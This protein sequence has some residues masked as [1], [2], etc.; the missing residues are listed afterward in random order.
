M[1]LMPDTLR[2]AQRR[3]VENARQLGFNHLRAAN[4]ERVEY[5]GHGTL[6]DGWNVAEWGCALAGEAGE[7]CNVLKKMNRQA[8]FDPDLLELKKE[9][10][11]EIADVLLYLDLLAAKLGILLD[12][13]ATVKFNETSKQYNFPVFL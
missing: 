10:E 13:A 6:D 7:L 1:Q 12:E 9:A 8:P 11:K 4:L 3:V 5:F 2:E